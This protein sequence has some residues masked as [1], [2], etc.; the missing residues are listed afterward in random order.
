MI[1]DFDSHLWAVMHTIAAAYPVVQTMSRPEKDWHAKKYRDFFESLPSVLPT[2]QGRNALHYALHEKD[3]KLTEQVWR[4]IN[5]SRDPKYQLSQR[6]FALHNLVRMRLEKKPSKESYAALYNR[7]RLNKTQP[8]KT[9]PNK[10]A[11]NNSTNKNANYTG[12]ME[13]QQLLKTRPAAMDVYLSQKLSDY[14][15]YSRVNRQAIRKSYLESAAKW[16]WKQ[17]AA[18]HASEPVQRKRQ[19]VLTDFKLEFQRL[20]NAPQKLVS[21]VKAFVP[22]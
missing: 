2:L 20:R 9:Q 22:F 21:H 19:L 7:Y 8:N 18:P 5:D 4:D 13:L 1:K 17:L 14:G 16:W 10:A 12:R 15:K 3:G 6:I 11:S